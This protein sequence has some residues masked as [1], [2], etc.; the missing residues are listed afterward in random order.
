MLRV[1]VR[2]RTRAAA[3]ASARRLDP[4][5]REAILQGARQRDPRAEVLARFEQPEIT[6]TRLRLTIVYIPGLTNKRGLHIL[7]IGQD[8]TDGGR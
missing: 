1:P 2:E 8:L 6:P 4:Q 3:E 7:R 5:L